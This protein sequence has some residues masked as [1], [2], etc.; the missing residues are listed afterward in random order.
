[1]DP[2]DST[3]A[4]TPSKTPSEDPFSS[5]REKMIELIQKRRLTDELVIEA[6]K[7]VPRHLFVPERWRA[8]AYN[9]Y[10][11]PIGYDQTISQ[12]YIVAFMTAQLQLTGQEK[13]LEIGTGSGYQAAVLAEIVDS[14]FTIEI[15]DSLAI[16]AQQILRNLN[17]GNIFFKIGDGYEGWIKYAPYDCIIVTAAPNHIPQALIDQLKNGGRMIIPVGSFWQEL[18]LVMKDEEGNISQESILPVRFVPM[19]GK[20]QEPDEN[21]ND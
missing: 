21:K 14:V 4:I 18:T 5:K 10:P 17:Y 13:V 7:K 16:K 6:M 2:E 9:D 11:L 3:A 1:M 19:T 20:A 12:P 15:I 8:Q